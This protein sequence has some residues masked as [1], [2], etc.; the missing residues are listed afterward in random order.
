[1]TSAGSNYLVSKIAGDV[2]ILDG[3][4]N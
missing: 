4:G 2:P 1:L 3:K